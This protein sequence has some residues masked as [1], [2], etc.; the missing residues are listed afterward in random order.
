METI[1]KKRNEIL[2]WQM[3]Y[4]NTLF[5][6]GFDLKVGYD[7]LPPGA[8][9]PEDQDDFFT[10]IG[11][12]MLS[13]D[14]IGKRQILWLESEDKPLQDIGE[15]VDKLAKTIR[16]LPVAVYIVPEDSPNT[17]VMVHDRY[18]QEIPAESDNQHTCRQCT[19][20]RT[21]P[22]GPESTEMALDNT[23]RSGEGTELPQERARSQ[24]PVDE[25]SHQDPRET[26]TVPLSVPVSRRS[27]GKDPEI[28]PDGSS[29]S[30]GFPFVGEVTFQGTNHTHQVVKLSV[31]LHLDTQ[32][33]QVGKDCVM[34]QIAMDCLQLQLIL[35]SVE[36]PNT[37]PIGLSET[38]VR[39]VALRLGI[40]PVGD[41]KKCSFMDPRPLKQHYLSN[42]VTNYEMVG[43]ATFTGFHAPTGSITVSGKKGVSKQQFPESELFDREKM[44]VEQHGCTG[45]RFWWYPLCGSKRTSIIPLMPHSERAMYQANKPLS[46]LKITL[47]TALEINDPGN[48]FYRFMWRT[49]NEVLSV[50]YK[51][52]KVRFA[53]EVR[54]GANENYLQLTGSHAE[55]SILTLQHQ[56]PPKNNSM[57][58][59]K[60]EVS[61]PD[62]PSSRVQTHITSEAH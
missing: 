23:L 30:T 35:P 62:I 27:R 45:E 7:L 31:G 58:P 40:L 57:T 44:R 6:F 43:G 32:L 2:E 46:G 10:G 28:I 1:E 48:A 25:R 37:R 36:K 59:N 16:P 60:V 61:S 54:R 49:S 26:A 9:I 5:R 4:W 19:F 18:Y 8:L 22:P 47:E 41:N 13:T 12:H 15:A 21:S 17:I 38:L 11:Q 34:T 29:I 56:L 42:I 3:E 52:C 55:G 14:A 39:A 33:P 51:H 50:A 24:D 20:I 53:V